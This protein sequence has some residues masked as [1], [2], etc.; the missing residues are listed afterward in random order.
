VI[1]SA[2]RGGQLDHVN[3]GTL[4]LIQA[5]VDNRSL[6][7][8]GEFE[9]VTLPFKRVSI[10]HNKYDEVLGGAFKYISMIQGYVTKVA[11]LSA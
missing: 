2:L 1:L 7:R 5:A 4:F 8:G 11:L 10:V 6:S 9:G 3:L